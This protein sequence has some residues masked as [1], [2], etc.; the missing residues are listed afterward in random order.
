MLAFV[1]PVSRSD[2]FG[3]SVQA[4]VRGEAGARGGAP[5]AECGSGGRRRDRGSAGPTPLFSPWLVGHNRLSVLPPSAATRC[6]PAAWRGAGL[7]ATTP[8]SPRHPRRPRLL[9]RPPGG[10]PDGEHPPITERRVLQCFPAY[11][12]ASRAPELRAPSAASLAP[13]WWAPRAPIP[14]PEGGHGL[15]VPTTTKA[16]GGGAPLGSGASCSSILLGLGKPRGDSPAR[17]PSTRAPEPL[18]TFTAS[19]APRW[20][21]PRSPAPI[22]KGGHGLVVPTSAAPGSAKTRQSTRGRSRHHGGVLQDVCS[23]SGMERSL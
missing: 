6:D 5:T 21:A 10:A 13:K 16:P 8:V 20:R 11:R 17:G 15:V 23:R 12:T 2:P 22:L 7:W 4:P 1:P 3:P 19:L 14:N 18:A 9:W